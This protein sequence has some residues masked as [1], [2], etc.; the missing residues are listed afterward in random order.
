MWSKRGEITAE[1]ERS[2]VF[3]ERDL[4]AKAQGREGT[5]GGRCYTTIS[6]EARNLVFFYSLNIACHSE[7][8]EEPCILFNLIILNEVRNLVF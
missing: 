7:R 6:S 1:N 2:R 8:S 5:Q 4:T 3:A